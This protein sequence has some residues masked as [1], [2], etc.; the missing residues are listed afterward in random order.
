MAK[1][2]RGLV[3]A[4]SGRETLVLVLALVAL[5]TAVAGLF[6]YQ[7]R[8]A[9]TD[10]WRGLAADIER[11]SDS[12]T[13]VSRETTQGFEPNGRV[14]TALGNDFEYFSQTLREGDASIGIAPISDEFQPDVD[15]LVASWSEISPTISTL[16]S[17]LGTYRITADAANSLI[18][19]LDQLKPSYEQLVGELRQR[20]ANS[21]VVA[22]IQ[23][24]RLERM[25]VAARSITD[26]AVDTT[27]LVQTLQ[28]L[29]DEFLRSHRALAEA[30]LSGDAAAQASAAATQFDTLIS[31]VNLIV[32]NAPALSAFNAAAASFLGQVEP[33]VRAANVVQQGVLQEVERNSGPPTLSYA[34]G[35]A[36]LALL[37]LFVYLFLEAVRRRSSRAGDRDAKQQQAILELLD[38]ITNLADGDLTVDVT[39][40]E[41]FTGAIAD[42]INYTVVN[43]RSLVGTITNTSVEIAAAASSTQETTRR[44]NAASERQTREIA[45]A[46]SVVARMSDSLSQVAGRA[47]QVSAQA[48]TSVEVAHNGATTVGRTIQGMA[49]LREQIQDTSKRIKRLGESS[50][51][52]GNI[53]ELIND[54]AEQTNTLALNASIQAAMAGEAGRGFAVVADEVQRLAER[55]A[56]ATRQIETLV[57]TI[58]A[59]T[60]EAIISMERSTSN[61]VGSARAA[62]EAGQALTQMES[63]S[64]ELSRLMSEIALAARAQSAEGQVVS[65]TMQ[66]VR[67]IAT[68]T[69]GSAARTAEAV[70]ELNV[71][72]E[73]LRQSVS[74][75]KLPNEIE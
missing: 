7:Q 50:Q 3:S 65:G 63:T 17:T 5:A 11:F 22:T 37:A 13:Q 74:G 18:I 31:Q 30:G 64:Q 71:L 38:E 9:R 6:V 43:M 67:E 61:V 34:A 52:I 24:V 40:T 58:Q 56:S 44:M 29:S 36:A 14:L 57:K 47:E 73:K 75:F 12:L 48:Q 45:S 25:A 46:S 41:D 33:M 39:V 26:I 16:A 8:V 70:G 72:S 60:N 20:S 62:E 2:S 69:S 21:S 51:E 35:A 68:E 66:V 19:T 27:P 4:V 55:A 59:D 53:T 15:R 1:Q 23:L 42:S 10:G 49:A 54:I 28:S 32:D